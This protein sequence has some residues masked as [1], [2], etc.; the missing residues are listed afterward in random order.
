MT[1]KP[2]VL[3]SIKHATHRLLILSTLISFLNA[4]TP[5]KSSIESQYKIVAYSTVKTTLKSSKSILISQSDAI[6]GYQT[7]QMLYTDTLYQLDA[8]AHSSWISPP[9]SMLTPLIVQ[10]LQHSHYFYAVAAGPNADKTDYRLDTQLIQLQQNFLTKPSTLEFSAQVVLTRVSDNRVIAS[11][12]FVERVPCATDTPYGGVIA[13]NRAIK[14]FTARV[15]DYV[16]TRAQS[17]QA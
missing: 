11:R 16:I 8:F 7:E 9:A 3:E 15:T 5:V 12:T 2:L 14:M 17:D 13:T 4:C 10:S 6:A 1:K